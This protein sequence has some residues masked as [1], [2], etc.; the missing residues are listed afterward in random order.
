MQ[1]PIRYSGIDPVKKTLRSSPR[2]WLSSS[3][4][5]F[6]AIRLLLREGVG[7]VLQ[8]DP[9]E[10]HV[11]VLGR[12]YFRPQHICRPPQMLSTPILGQVIAPS[13]AGFFP[14]PLFFRPAFVLACAWLKLPVLGCYPRLRCPWPLAKKAHVAAESPPT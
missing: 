10:H 8:E 5:H 7:D 2:F 11:L 13:L 14:R 1:N 3:S 9:P 6:P 12:I 4:L